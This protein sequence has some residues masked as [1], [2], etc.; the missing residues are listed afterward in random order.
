MCK[1]YYLLIFFVIAALSARAQITSLPKGEPVIVNRDTLFKFYAPQ[2]L[3]DPAER[4]GTVTKR[5]RAL[6]DRIDFNPDSLTLKNDTALSVIYYNS[7]IILAV[8]NKDATYSEL[9][10]PQLAASYL[11]ILKKNLGNYFDTN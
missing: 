9:N 2:G 8:T 7:Q 1:N 10:R 5:I 3:F 4:A 11:T 6:V